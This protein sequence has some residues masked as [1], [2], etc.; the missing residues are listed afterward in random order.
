MRVCVYAEVPITTDSQYFF[1]G[2][3]EKLWICDQVKNTTCTFSLFSIATSVGNFEQQNTAQRIFCTQKRH[4]PWSQCQY[5]SGNQSLNFFV[6]VFHVTFLANHRFCI[7]VSNFLLIDFCCNS[8]TWFLLHLKDI[9]AVSNV[10][11]RGR[12]QARECK[13]TDLHQ[14]QCWSQLNSQDKLIISLASS[15]QV[16]MIHSAWFWFFFGRY[17]NVLHH[18]VSA[19]HNQN[20]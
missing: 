3:L 18:I 16:H 20:E 12:M 2:C 9:S 13:V 19:L 14:F 8:K 11:A 1:Y 10:K 6:V 7:I 17:D 15:V 4:R 5:Y